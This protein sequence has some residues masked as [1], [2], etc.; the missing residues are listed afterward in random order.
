MTVRADSIT[1]ARR[2]LD[3]L[4]L[5][6]AFGECFFHP[7]MHGLPDDAA[8]AR[9]LPSRPWR[10][11]DDTAMAVQLARCLEVQG[12]VDCDD[13]ASRF[14]TAYMA[15]PYRGY[16]AS[17][18]RL[19]VEIYAGRSW[20]EAAYEGFGGTGSMGN[21]A[22]MRVAPLGAYFAGGDPATVLEQAER[23]AVVTHPHA[24]GVAG[25]QAVALA[26]AFAAGRD[27][28]DFASGLFG[29]LLAHLPLSAVR[30]VIEA[31]AALPAGVA[32]A[33]IARDFGNGSR[34]LTTDTV[35]TCLWLAANFG[36]DFAE[37]VWQTADVRGDVD[38]NC[39]IVGGIVSLLNGAALPAEWK[40]ARLAVPLV[41]E[42]P[43]VRS[44]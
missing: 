18:Q 37:A 28:A 13:L 12:E 39:A 44:Q 30:G 31:V 27:A 2:S 24:E 4:S 20:R 22:A 36:S 42:P 9:V 25:A 8:A 11:T 38:T 16:G 40:A 5:G 33:R 17:V 43:P 7:I 3:G 15:D 34:L 41:D 35:P 19:L 6:D 1:R 29:E 14:A 32:P 21:G 23:S 26:A 10:W